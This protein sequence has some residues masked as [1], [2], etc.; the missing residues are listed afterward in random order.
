[1]VEEHF[2]ENLLFPIHDADGHIQYMGDTKQ[3][4][5]RLID[6]PQIK[7]IRGCPDQTH[8]SEVTP[9][10]NVLYNT[11]KNGEI[12]ATCATPVGR[13]PG[14]GLL[15]EIR[16]IT[17]QV[18]YMRLDGGNGA[19]YD[20]PEND[21]NTGWLTLVS[22]YPNYESSI[23]QTDIEG[24]INREEKWHVKQQFIGDDQVIGIKI[25]THD[26][27]QGISPFNIFTAHLPPS[28]VSWTGWGDSLLLRCNYISNLKNKWIYGEVQYMDEAQLLYRGV[29]RTL[30][31]FM[32][33][34]KEHNQ[35]MMENALQ[36]KTK[37]M[38]QSKTDLK[39]NILQEE[40]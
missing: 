40:I 5:C 2:M 23:P 18:R 30:K 11:L 36:S 34:S 27:N 35:I 8:G 28:I 24:L 1:M 25:Q 29:K 19:L 32:N 15:K 3:A 31:D 21:D 16:V 20:D 37:L 17:M 9:H 33:I 6:Y 10:L 39:L 4:E 7:S 26:N 38:M 13:F 12:R 14:C 22:L